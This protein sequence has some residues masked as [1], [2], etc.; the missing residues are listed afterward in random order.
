M[1]KWDWTVAVFQY[2]TLEW[3]CNRI[4]ANFLVCVQCELVLF[5]YYYYWEI[6][7]PYYGFILM[8]KY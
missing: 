6:L 3:N 7:F 2:G 8:H 1:Q 4:Y 5:F